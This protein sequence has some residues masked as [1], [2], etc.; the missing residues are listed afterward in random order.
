MVSSFVLMDSSSW[1]MYVS[2]CKTN[3][4]FGSCYLWFKGK[5]KLKWFCFLIFGCY[6]NKNKK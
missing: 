5:K 2:F 3:N 1:A 6:E 4:M